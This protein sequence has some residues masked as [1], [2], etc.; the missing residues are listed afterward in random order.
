[1][2][3]LYFP[4]HTPPTAA[5]AEVM[6]GIPFQLSW[7]HGRLRL[8]FFCEGLSDYQLLALLCVFQGSRPRSLSCDECWGRREIFRVFGVENAPFRAVQTMLALRDYYN[9]DP[10]L[11]EVPIWRVGIIEHAEFQF[12][13]VSLSF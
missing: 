5:L 6:E 12:L 11:V 4:P 10:Y 1:M 7:E 13:R 8:L 2:I 3:E 9:D